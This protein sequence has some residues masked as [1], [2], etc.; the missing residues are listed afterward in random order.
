QIKTDRSASVEGE[1]DLK[2]KK[3]AGFIYVATEYDLILSEDEKDLDQTYVYSSSKLSPLSASEFLFETPA[4]EDQSDH[5]DQNS[6]LALESDSASDEAGSST[7]ASKT[8]TP[9]RQCVK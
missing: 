1:K 6:V 8:N 5:S 4:E 7:S 9:V 3:R 2:C